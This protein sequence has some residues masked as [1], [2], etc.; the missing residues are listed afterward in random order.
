VVVVSLVVVV[1][2]IV[3]VVVGGGVV[4]VV[5][6]VVGGG[7]GGGGGGGYSLTQT[8]TCRLSLNM[9]L[10]HELAWPWGSIISGHRLPSLA[11]MP[12][13]TLKSSAGRPH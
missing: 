3:V 6:V 9:F 13:C 4:V 1:V 5:V 10:V 8:H 12:F 11:N 2:V 7:G